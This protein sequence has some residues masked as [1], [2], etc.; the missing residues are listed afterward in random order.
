MKRI[1]I[2]ENNEQDFLKARLPV[3][4][5]LKTQY[6]FYACYP[7]S[8]RNLQTVVKTLE[9]PLERNNKSP[10]QLLSLSKL[11]RRY[12]LEHEIDLI[13][14]FRFQ[15]NI[16]SILVSLN[17]LRI[18]HIT[19]LGSAFSG[20]LSL[21]KVLSLFIYQIIL[22][23]SKYVITQNGDDFP[24]INLLGPHFFKKNLII[25]GSGVDTDVFKPLMCTS[26]AG[27]SEFKI[28]LITRLLKSKGVIELI[29]AVNLINQSSFIASHSNYKHVKLDIVGWIDDCNPD[30]ISLEEIQIFR[31]DYIVFHGKHDNVVPFYTN[32]NLFCFPSK[33]REGIPRVLLEALSCGLP[34]ITTDSPGCKECING[35]GILIS[36]VSELN[37]FNS[38]INILQMTDEKIKTMGFNSRRMAEER[39]SKEV[40]GGKFFD[41]YNEIFEK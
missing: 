25:Y 21:D 14:S 38:I 40:V 6:E 27:R 32:S 41:L 5:I 15:P 23:R 4:E 31:N 19:G 9:F 1:L 8:I 37:I 7:G 39:F 30:S 16:I 35:N 24:D 17:T 12:V 34:I 33:Y 10:F 22:V 13:H 36:E 18:C 29:S 26:R 3:M 11:I 2:I 28:L 20:Y